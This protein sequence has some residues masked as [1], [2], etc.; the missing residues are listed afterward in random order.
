MKIVCLVVMVVSHLDNHETSYY[1]RY[2]FALKGIPL[3]PGTHAGAKTLQGS[4]GFTRVGDD[5]SCLRCFQSLPI[6][7]EIAFRIQCGIQC[8]RIKIERLGT[9]RKRAVA[10]YVYSNC[11]GF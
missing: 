3:D 9:S 10:L 5:L 6:G 4:R 11:F 2:D 7:S 8:L 1:S